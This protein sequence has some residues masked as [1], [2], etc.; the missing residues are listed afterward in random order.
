MSDAAS[1][2]SSCSSAAIGVSGVAERITGE[3]RVG[4]R[5]GATRKL[6]VRRR[7]AVLP[8]TFTLVASGTLAGSGG[9][10]GSGDGSFRLFARRSLIVTALFLTGV[11][12]CA[13][14][15]LATLFLLAAA[16]ESICG[17]VDG[18][19]GT[20][21]LAARLVRTIAV[22]CEW[23]IWQIFRNELWG[24]WSRSCVMANGHRPWLELRRVG[25]LS[26]IRRDRVWRTCGAHVAQSVARGEC[27][28]PHRK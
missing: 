5:L 1:S 12:R 16:V 26:A 21:C 17:L 19:E 11:E 4:R 2:S 7:A 18:G 23:C 28:A 8:A 9:G 10:D 14:L 13:T 3:G 27:G 6:S 25:L 24:S 15:F 20:A 22:V